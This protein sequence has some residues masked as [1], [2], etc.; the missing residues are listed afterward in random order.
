MVVSLLGQPPHYLVRSGQCSE[1]IWNI[2]ALLT[3]VWQD[4]C[5]P[6]RPE[7][8]KVRIC[9]VYA[10]DSLCMMNRGKVMWFIYVVYPKISAT[11][12]FQWVAECIA[13]I[14]ILN[15]VTWFWNI[16]DNRKWCLSMLNNISTILLILFLFF[17][18]RFVAKGKTLER[19]CCPLYS[20]P[21]N[22]FRKEALLDW[23]I[24]CEVNPTLRPI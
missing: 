14:D 7:S 1:Q 16:W 5:A 22:A 10:E 3:P 13:K 17:I 19:F 4:I 6:E 12:P 24:S 20:R 23:I 18:T 8:S 11:Q 2:F 15:R 21:D 9:R